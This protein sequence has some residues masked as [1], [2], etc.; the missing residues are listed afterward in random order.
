MLRHNAGMNHFPIPPGIL[1]SR[2]RTLQ[3]LGGLAASGTVLAAAPQP[4]R[5]GVIASWSG[6]YADY[7]RQF[8]AGMAVYLQQHGERLGGLPVE[9]VRRDVPG[10]APDLARRAAQELIV[11]DKVQYLGGVYFTPDAMAITPLLKQGNVPLVIFNAATSAIMN[12]SPLVVRMCA[13]PRSSEVCGP[14]NA[15]ATCC[16]TLSLVSPRLDASTLPVPRAMMPSLTSVPANASATSRTVPSPPIA[17]TR[18]APSA[19]H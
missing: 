13:C 7:G 17:M 3:L 18:S 11:R 14:R 6:P 19:T 16:P 2:R 8:D 12:S 5:I 4:L 1:P 9:L 10:A 15:V